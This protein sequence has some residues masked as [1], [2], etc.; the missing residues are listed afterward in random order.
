MKTYTVY[1]VDYIR[2]STEPVGTMLERRKKD[3][4]DNIDALL[5]LAK[6]IFPTSSPDSHICISPE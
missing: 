2:H 5:K 1:R 3:R 6:K 4:G